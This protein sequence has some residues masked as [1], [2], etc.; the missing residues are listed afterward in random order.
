MDIPRDLV[1]IGDAARI[2]R[3]HHNTIR[4]WIRRGLVQLY[5]HR[6]CERVSLSQVVPPVTSRR[7]KVYYTPDD[8]PPIW[9]SY[10]DKAVY[11]KF[12]K[13]PSPAPRSPKG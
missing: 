9:R 6:G 13:P 5:G 4:R 3:I 10:K 11:S 12:R 1:P 2:A 8:Q 7:S